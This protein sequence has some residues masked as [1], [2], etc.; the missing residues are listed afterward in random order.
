MLIN[1]ILSFFLALKVCY[2]TSEDLYN[3][4]GINKHATKAEI[5][6]AYRQKA[7]DTHPDKNPGVD[8]D[9]AADSFRKVAD[10]INIIINS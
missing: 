6:K 4:L 8:P 3:V 7:K 9:V 1:W 10:V 2:C 5:K